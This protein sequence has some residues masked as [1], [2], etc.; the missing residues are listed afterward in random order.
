MAAQERAKSPF[1]I[2]GSGG[3]NSFSDNDFPARFNTLGVRDE[4]KTVQIFK[5][6]HNADTK[7]SAI[8][9]DRYG[10]VQ[11]ESYQSRM[12][13]LILSFAETLSKTAR[14]SPKWNVNDE[15]IRNME[16][17]VDK[18][19]KNAKAQARRLVMTEQAFFS[20]AAQGQCYRELGIEKFEIVATLDSITSEICQN[21]DGKV[22]DTKDHQPGVTA[23]PFHVECR[24]TTVPFFDD[25]FGFGGQRAA[26]DKDGKTYY[27]PDDM[28]YE[29]WA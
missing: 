13:M 3:G 6:K 27:V 28:K 18:K 22:F 17:F 8:V 12:Q 29:D 9:I 19:F 10:F 5:D 21:L 2:R 4:K 24:S 11:L 26:R 14:I 25:E 7:E 15:A 23:N 16:K 20:S 1:L